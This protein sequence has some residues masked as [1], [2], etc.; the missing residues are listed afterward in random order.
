MSQIKNLKFTKIKIGMYSPHLLH[1]LYLST[2]CV[3]YF[4][5]VVLRYKAWCAAKQFVTNYSICYKE[6]VNPLS[7]QSNKVAFVCRTLSCIKKKSI[8]LGG[9]VYMWTCTYVSLFFLIPI[10][11]FSKLLDSN[12]D[13]NSCMLCYLLWFMYVK[14]FQL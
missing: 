12:F 4:C 14:T 10:I 5:T 2:P 6:M 9:F 7:F 1:Y 11:W 8:C 13:N 3:V